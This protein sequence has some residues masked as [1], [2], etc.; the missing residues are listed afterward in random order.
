MTG[1]GFHFQ[2]DTYL[3]YWQFID[4]NYYAPTCGAAF[5]TCIASRRLQNLLTGIVLQVF[6]IDH[7]K[8]FHI[9]YFI[10]GIVLGNL[11]LSA[12]KLTAV[13]TLAFSDRIGMVYRKPG[14]SFI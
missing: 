6:P 10:T 13:S 8:V 5:F 7:E 11:H 12:R 9:L 4:P 14:D 3:G 1:R 2:G